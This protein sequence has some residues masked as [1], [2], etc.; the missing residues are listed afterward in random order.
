MIRIDIATEFSDTPAGRFPDDGPFN[1]E[2]FRKKFLVPALKSGDLVEVSMDGTEGFGS[3]FLDEAFGGLV[4]DEGFTREYVEQ[5][6]T[7][8]ANLKR[9]A[10][11]KRLAETY[12]RDAVPSK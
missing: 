3:S 8:I 9:T 6:L 10:R 4:R 12:I 11:Y 1:G 2:F 7:L 5:H